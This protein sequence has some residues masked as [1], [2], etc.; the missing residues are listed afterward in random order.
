MSS[1]DPN[2][3]MSRACQLT[4]CGRAAVIGLDGLRHPRNGVGRSTM[5]GFKVGLGGR[6]TAPLS[7]SSI[8]GGAKFQLTGISHSVILV[9]M[10]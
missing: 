2:E 7:P 10:R 4:C 6:L 1:C 9:F 5:H 8:H 3:W